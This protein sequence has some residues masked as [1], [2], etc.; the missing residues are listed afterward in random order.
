MRPPRSHYRSTSLYTGCT[1]PQDKN[2]AVPAFVR[3]AQDHPSSPLLLRASAFACLAFVGVEDIPDARVDILAMLAVCQYTENCAALGHGPPIVF[4]VAHKVQD[5]GLR[6][7]R[8]AQVA[9]NDPTASL[10]GRWT[11]MWFMTDWV[12]AG[13]GVRRA[14]T[15]GPEQQTK[16]SGIYACAGCGLEPTKK[17]DLKACKGKHK[18]VDPPLYCGKECQRKARLALLW[19]STFTFWLSV[20]VDNC[21][22]QDWKRHKRV[23]ERVT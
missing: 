7:S 20:E 2:A 10:F 8:P 14:V 22:S 4:R 19:I 16:T 13:G 18:G 11:N 17:S 5:A 6:P 1:V 3:A 9:E 12:A 15:S 21:G 23:C